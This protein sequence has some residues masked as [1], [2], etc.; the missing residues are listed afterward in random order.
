MSALYLTVLAP[1]VGFVIL[2]FSRSK[3]S[4]NAA[5]VVGVGSVGVSALTTALAIVQ[6]DGPYRQVLWDKINPGEFGF[7]RPDLPRHRPGEPPADIF[8][9]MDEATSKF[10]KEKGDKIKLK[11]FVQ[12]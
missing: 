10:L 2:A 1:L 6:F 11:R 12:R 8:T 5:A 7:K 9:P 3:I 4:E